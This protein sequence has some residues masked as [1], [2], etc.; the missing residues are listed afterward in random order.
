MN[1]QQQ[2]ALTAILNSHAPHDGRHATAIPWL[3]FYK[4]SHPHKTMLAM[5]T[6]SI[7]FVV[8]GS[9]EV[10]LDNELYC[11][12]ASDYLAVSVDLPIASQINQATPETPFLCLQIDID[13]LTLNDVVLQN[14]NL[15]HFTPD[16]RRGLA[17]GTANTVLTDAIVRLV[18]LLDRQDD[19]SFL[20][21][22][23]IKEIYYYLLKTPF[24]TQIAHITMAGSAEYTI[25]Q[26]IAYLKQHIHRSVRID[27]LAAMVHM[28]VS[29]FHHVFKNATAMSPLQYHKRLRLLE[30]R[31]LMVNEKMDAST[32][33]LS[34][35]YE[36]AS[37]FSR[38]YRRLFGA[39]P[40][41]DVV[42]LRSQKNI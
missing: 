29:T 38:D 23:V 13:A 41:Q 26:V 22:L 15:S 4:H 14:S 18:T 33:G 31:R 11:Y 32:A 1:E 28:S 10:L 35:G 16:V 17:V 42:K 6:P 25:A 34:V 39:P 5:Y 36:S 8:Q 12:A 19:I 37:Q 2:A 40:W 30:A 20:A 24:G 9:K 21:P 27:E 7:Y 3:H